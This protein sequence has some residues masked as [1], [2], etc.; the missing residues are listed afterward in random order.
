MIVRA[1][2]VPVGFLFLRSLLNA[3]YRLMARALRNYSLLHDVTIGEVN[4]KYI[5]ILINAMVVSQEFVF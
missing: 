1:V 2:S 3:W 5:A 4:I